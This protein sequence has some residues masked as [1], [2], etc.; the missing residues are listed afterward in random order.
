MVEYDDFVDQVHASGPAV[1]GQGG[2]TS[3]STV[4]QGEV[5]VGA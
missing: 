5:P 2:L 1:T 4:L 3:T